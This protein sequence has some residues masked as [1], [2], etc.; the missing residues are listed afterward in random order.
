MFSRTFLGFPRPR[1]PFLFGRNG[2]FSVSVLKIYPSRIASPKPKSLGLQGE[3]RPKRLTYSSSTAWPQCGLDNRSQW[4]GNGTLDYN[5]LPDFHNFRRRKG[6][7]LEIPSVQA[8]FALRSRSSPWE[9]RSAS[10][11]HLAHSGPHPPNTRSPDPCSDFTSSFDPSAHS[12]L[13][14]APNPLQPPDPVS[15]SPT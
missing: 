14:S 5:T 2:K 1:L 12:P 7:W 6:K 8:F 11:I 10:Q 15:Q 3:I 4:P 13:P 9:S